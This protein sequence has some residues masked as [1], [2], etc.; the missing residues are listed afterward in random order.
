MKTKELMFKILNG[1]SLGIVATL[2]PSAILG[3]IAKSLNLMNLLNL[4]KISTSLLPF[5]IGTGVSYQ[6]SFTPLES[7]CVSVATFIGSGVVS[8]TNGSI[9][10]TGTGDVVNAGVTA[11]IA[12]LA[13]YFFRQKVKSLSMVALPIIISIAVGW[14]G[15]TLLPLISKINGG[16][17]MAIEEIVKMQ[18]L[19]TGGIIAIIFSILII[20]PFSTVGIALAVNLSGIAAGAANLGVCA[21]AF[22]LALAG[23]KVNPIG[24]TLVPVLGS[25]KIQMANFVK[26]PLI[27]IPIITNAFI[28][29]V[30]GAFFNIKGTAFSAGFGISGLIGPI[31]ALNH[32]SWDL[33]NII[34]VFVLFIVLPIFFGYICNFIFI[35]KLVLIKEEDYKI[36]I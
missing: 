35:N 16:I 9:V 5:A 13:I 34:I 27:I 18:P 7:I 36:S 24:I 17:G 23:F 29:G 12:S 6:L 21:A 2:I 22:G 26:N 8:F 19:L 25:A 11:F 28:L 20:S 1:M 32:M 4:T 15:L 10:L 33:K 30:L 31:N 14:I 3:E